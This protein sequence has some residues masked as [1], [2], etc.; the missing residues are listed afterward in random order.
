MAA[1]RDSPLCLAKPREETP[2]LSEAAAKPMCGQA[3]EDPAAETI[4]ALA[5]SDE[6]GNDQEWVDKPKPPPIDKGEC[7]LRGRVIREILE[8]EE[9]YFKNLQV[10]SH[11]RD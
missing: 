1:R 6:A 2:V 9:A 7:F 8:T 10:A 4:V 11:V 3:K 5:A